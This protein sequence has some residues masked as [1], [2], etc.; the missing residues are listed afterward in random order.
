MCKCCPGATLGA[1]G[2]SLK[3]NLF[4]ELSL[5]IRHHA[6]H[7]E[8]DREAITRM[9]SSLIADS[10]LRVKEVGARTEVAVRWGSHT[11]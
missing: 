6:Q 1:A 11:P 8:C 3:R 4:I 7:S 10:P 5:H 9:Q 2:R